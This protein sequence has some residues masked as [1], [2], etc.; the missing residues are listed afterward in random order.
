MCFSLLNLSKQNIIYESVLSVLSYLM[1]NNARTEE[2]NSK[3]IIQI[4]PYRHVM[5]VWKPFVNH[6]G[7]KS[8][9]NPISSTTAQP[10]KKENLEQAD[11]FHSSFPV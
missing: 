4:T 3:Y 2:M 9:N 11:V 8:E 1:L 7:L 6:S 5:S 10:R